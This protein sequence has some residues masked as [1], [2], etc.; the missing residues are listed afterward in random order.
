MPKHIIDFIIEYVLKL[1]FLDGYRMYA[2]GAFMVL[3]GLG[4]VANQVA[5][6]VYDSASFE[7]GL[8][9][10]AMGL[11]VTGLAGKQDKIASEV[12]RG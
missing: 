5:S 8:T 3:T 7:K 1:K 11:S 9:L 4:I 10:I 12:K 6:G 2:G